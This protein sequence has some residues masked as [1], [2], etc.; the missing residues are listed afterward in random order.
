MGFPIRVLKRI[1][2][3]VIRP[4]KPIGKALVH[5]PA[6]ILR[7]LFRRLRKR[8]FNFWILIA[9]LGVSGYM[10]WV[11]FPFSMTEISTSQRDGLNGKVNGM[12][13][14]LDL[15]G[16]TH[17]VYQANLEEASYE[18]AMEGAIDIVRDRI[19]RY[20]VA[21]PIIQQQG[22]DRLLIQL[23]GVEDV[24]EAKALIG[25]TAALDFRELQE[26]G[27]RNIQWVKAFDEAGA[28]TNIVVEVE[29]GMGTHEWVPAEAVGSDGG[30]KHLTGVYLKPNCRARLGGALGTQPEVTIEWDSEGAILFE[31]ITGRLYPGRDPLGIFLDDEEV[32]HP[33]VQAVL[34]DSGVITG[35]TLSE[36][37]NLAIQLNSGA[38]PVPLGRWGDDEF[39]TG[40]PMFEDTVSATLGEDFVKWGVMAFLIG[41]GLVMVFMI[42][43]YRVPGVM[44][45]LALIIYAL[46]VLGVFKLIPVTLTLAGIGGFVLSV[47]MAVDANVLIFERM[48]EELRAG[49]TLGASID[50]GFDR[51]WVAILHSNVST[52]IICGVLYW[53]GSGVVESPQVQ[54]FALTL[55]IGVALSMLSA[56]VVTRTL[57][58]FFTGPRM[59]RRKS[60]FG[61]EPRVEEI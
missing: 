41:I 11:L 58:R 33:T 15:K 30:V 60:W 3:A 57:L 6:S 52:L 22:D 19:D 39:L 29:P 31:E 25:Q 38:L 27:Q 13:L 18:G 51:A 28:P 10:F 54:G 56:I 24:D 40:E 2:K 16:G 23:P 8:S 48:R 43:Y 21:E 50:V 9:V 44:A 12:T 34:S 32:S 20:G 61:P 46:V 42:L 26:G 45:A 17:L 1:G 37:E 7:P 55:A 5:P 36:A 4:L 35:L 53:F 47:G 49:R 59:A 14:G